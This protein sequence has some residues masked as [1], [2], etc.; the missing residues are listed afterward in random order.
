VYAT[1]AAAGASV[2][3]ATRGMIGMSEP[4]CRPI[5][6]S[7]PMVRAL[8]E[9]RKSQTRRALKHQPIDILAMK[10]D[11]RC[12]F[13]VP[14]DT[15]WVR[16]TWAWP[17]E[18][19]VIYRADASAEKLVEHWKTDPN[20]PQIK[21]RPSIFMPRWASRITLR[22]TDVRVERL[23]SI[24]NDDAAAEGWP[25]PDENNSIASAYPIAWYVRVWQSIHGPGSWKHDP[26]VWVVSFERVVP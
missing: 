2:A 24:S 10:G 4:R 22:V 25:G 23:A 9:G 18:E 5:L 1:V 21:W 13:G 17:G 8:L 16:E 3:P 15:L 26:W 20:F 7:A 6:F 12:R 19:Q 11:Q 14:G